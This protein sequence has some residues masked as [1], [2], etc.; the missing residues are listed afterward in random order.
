MRQW[1]SFG[2]TPRH[3]GACHGFS[4]FS[5]DRKR[6]EAHGATQVMCDLPSDQRAIPSQTVISG[7]LRI[8]SRRRRR[9]NQST[10]ARTANSTASSERRGPRRRMTSVMTDATCVQILRRCQV[11]RGNFLTDVYE[12]ITEDAVT[13]GTS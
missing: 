12:T 3:A 1:H 13:P 5:S 8:G 7:R 9:L 2:R 4:I 6:T 10:H 11:L